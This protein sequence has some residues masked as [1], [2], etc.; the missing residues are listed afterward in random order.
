M[1][2]P[3]AGHVLTPP[4]EAGKFADMV[5]RI[6]KWMDFP[7]SGHLGGAWAGGLRGGL[8]AFICGAALWLVLGPVAAVG[9]SVVPNGTT[10]L[11]LGVSDDW[12]DS[13][14]V[15][16]RFER[17]REGWRQVGEPWQGRLGREGS[18]WGLGLHPQRGLAGPRKRE[19][20]RRA[21]AGVFRIAGAYGYAAADE[22]RLGRGLSY[23]QVG[24][25]DMWV[26]D[27]DSPH[28]NR[29]IQAAGGRPLTEWEKKQQMIQNDPVHALKLFIEHNAAE[30]VVPGGGSAIFFHIWRDEGRRATAG[31]T[32]MSEAALRD[33]IAWVE[34]ARQ[35]V[36]VLLPREEFMRWRERWGL[37]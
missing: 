20:D 6:F 14:V 32:T 2:R 30:E 17:T 9:G 21:P 36:Y 5:S 19:G 15:L 28:Y 18:A 3:R 35:P 10:Q 29:H 31:C 4:E 22:V 8:G 7:F 25:R 1:A 23:H 24:P 13:H 33:L 27:P 12:D 11:L 34:P 16:R 37:P 26:E